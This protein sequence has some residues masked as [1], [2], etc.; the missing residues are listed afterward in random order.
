LQEH[1]H[2]DSCYEEVRVLTCGRE[3]YKGHQHTDACYEKVLTC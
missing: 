3:E 1:V 2:D